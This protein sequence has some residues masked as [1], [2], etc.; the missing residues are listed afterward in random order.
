MTTP[1]PMRILLAPSPYKTTSTTNYTSTESIDI[2]V[3]N[4]T[5]TDGMK[6]AHSSNQIILKYKASVKLAAA[7]KHPDVKS[8][9]KLLLDRLVLLNVTEGKVSDV[10]AR[11]KDD[12]D[13]EYI[14]PNYVTTASFVPNDPYYVYQWHFVKIQMEQAW[15]IS[16]GA[17][18]T[19]AV[20]DTGIAYENYLGFQKAPDLAGTTFTSGYDFVNNDAHPND[21]EGHGTHVCGTIAQTTN[22]GIGVAGIAFNAIIMPVKA[23][24]SNGV[25]YYSWLIDG[26]IWAVDHGAKIINMSLGGTA[27]SSALEDAVDYAYNNGVALV[28][29]AGNSGTADMDYPARYTHVISVG[30]IRYDETRSYYS[31]YGSRLDF[32][33]PG[34]DITVDQNSDGYADGVLQQTFATGDPTDFA[35]YFSQGTSMAAPHVSGLAAL[36]YSQGVTT[37]DQ[38]KQKMI[39]GAKDLGSSG[40]DAQYGYGL[41]QAYDSL[42]VRIT[43]TS[44]PTGYGFVKVDDS[45]ITTPQVF[46]WIV[47]SSHTVDV[48]SIV[49]GGTGIQYVWVSWSDGGSASHTIIVTSAVTYTANFKT[50]YYLT[51]LANPAGGGGVSPSSGWQDAGTTVSA[52]A[53]ANSGYSF[54]YWSLDGTNVGS[55][56]SYSVLMD[57]P[58]SLT[59]YFRSTSSI[60]VGLSAGS[61]VLGSS[62]T[63]SGTITPAQPLPGIPTGTTVTLSYSPDGAL[64]NTF[65]ITKTSSGGAYSIVWYPPYPGTHQIKATWNGNSDYE[66]SESSTAALTVT[67]TLPPRI[68]LLIS[69]PTSAARGDSATFD[70]IV[71]NPGSA[72]NTTLY[73]EVTGADDY[74]HYDFQQVSVSAGGTG[75]FQFTWQ[76]PSTVTTGPYQ[77]LVSLIPPKPTAIART[78]IAIT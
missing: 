27:D 18:V 19:V 68:T 55:S 43:V 37:P 12:P 34:G 15:D 56:P 62:A 47:G 28:A 40:W 32:V 41:I 11:L 10:I 59:A 36:L 17:G 38:I 70:V 61:I 65:I 78:E 8:E 42:S 24:D 72:I 25:G 58:H 48:N 2:K 51:T 67:G 76:I 35:Y 29:A 3:K 45:W 6:I 30:A 49:D 46:T 26:I 57:S 22:N 69:G 7:Q 64:W 66:G 52:A 4:R 71:T 14:E 54:Y 75:R 31:N 44:S 63:L 23:L 33:A 60:S 16:T 5:K 74:K 73:F 21:D 13:I 50:Q 20:I 9:K 1:T 77:V 39:E 53:A